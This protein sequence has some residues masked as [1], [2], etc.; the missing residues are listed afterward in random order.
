MRAVL[1]KTDLVCYAFL[2]SAL[3]YSRI[4]NRLQF[5]IINDLI[6]DPHFSGTSLIIASIFDPCVPLPLRIR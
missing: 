4:R 3:E 2:E 5:Q 1:L 6:L